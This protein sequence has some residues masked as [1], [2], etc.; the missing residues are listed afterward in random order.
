MTVHG[1]IEDGVVRL[2]ADDN[3]DAWIEAEYREGWVRRKLLTD[4]SDAYQQMVEPYYFRCRCCRRYLSTQR[5]GKGL[6]YC[7]GCEQQW[8]RIGDWFEQTAEGDLPEP[9][10]CPECGSVDVDLEIFCPSTCN[11]CGSEFEKQETTA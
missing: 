11:D 5:W 9:T 1:S 3:D 7:P 6:P 8:Y 2:E 4:D 10:Q